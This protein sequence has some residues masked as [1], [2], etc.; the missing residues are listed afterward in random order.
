[1]WCFSAISAL[2]FDLHHM[3][4]LS[5]G[6]HEITLECSIGTPRDA[7]VLVMNKGSKRAGPLRGQGY[8]NLVGK[9]SLGIRNAR[10]LNLL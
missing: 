7:G 5:K 9:L 8:F 1:M 10:V 4:A 2:H 6:F 3:A